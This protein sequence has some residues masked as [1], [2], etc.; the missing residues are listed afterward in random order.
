MEISRDLGEAI[1]YAFP[2]IKVDVHHPDVL[3]NVEVRNEIYVYS[4]I[5]P[6]AGGSR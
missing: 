4:E 5:I 2:E 1:L 6:G 3:V